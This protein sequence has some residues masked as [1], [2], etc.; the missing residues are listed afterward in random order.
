MTA[1]RARGH[2]L[3]LFAPERSR[4]HQEARQAGF[5]VH[6]LDDRKPSY[7]LTILRLA[8]CFRR[9]K[10]DVVNPHSSRDGWLGCVAAR[11]AGVPVIIRSRHIEVDYPN[12][13]LSRIAFVKLP[14]HVIT[15]SDKISARLVA[16]LG[17]PAS[18]VS[19]IATG[20]NLERFHPGVPGVLHAELGFAPGM[21]IVGMIS[22]LRSWK[23]HPTFIEAVKIV[24]Q[25][26]PDVRFIIAGAGEPMG[27]HVRQL[28]QA[29][30]L[31]QKITML[32]HRNDVP[33]LLAS[34]AVLVLPS[35]G[36]EG[37]PQI[38]LQAQAMA[39]AVVG[40]AVGGIPEVVRDGVTGLLVPPLDPSA[41]ADRILRLLEDPALR[42]TLGRQAREHLVRE[43]SLPRMCERLEALY[44]QIKGA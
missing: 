25:R 40:T 15:T 41:L 17:L 31:E 18:Q 22:V 43:H 12:R 27:A 37:I 21:P 38:I 3:L 7:P 19:C 23:G 16:E 28:I 5:E 11:L 13:F 44:Q 34:L 9:E 20:V 42:E 33:Q 35:T 2:R 4:I 30:G 14:H 26:R 32:G 6:P 1:M 24:A 36:H 39:R 29:A 8:R 10:V